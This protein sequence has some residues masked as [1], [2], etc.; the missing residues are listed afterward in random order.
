MLPDFFVTGSCNTAQF[1]TFRS[2]IFMFYPTPLYA[3]PHL[4]PPVLPLLHF[5][6]EQPWYSPPHSA[7]GNATKRQQP[8][9]ASTNSPGLEKPPFPEAAG[10][11]KQKLPAGSLVRNGAFHSRRSGQ[12][13]RDGLSQN[14]SST[15][16]NELPDCLLLE[17]A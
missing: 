14:R 10:S 3:V 16:A 13:K 12:W 7:T 1:L 8:P 6:K 11:L 2:S 15:G 9:A 4:T 5:Q 17:Q